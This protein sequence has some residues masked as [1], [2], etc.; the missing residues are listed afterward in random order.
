[1]KQF[2]K[3]KQD[4]SIPPELQPY[5]NEQ[6]PTGSKRRRELT[7]ALAGLAGLIVIGLLIWGGFALF[8]GGSTTKQPTTKAPKTHQPATSNGRPSEKNSGKNNQT[9]NNGKNN[10]SQSSAKTGQQPSQLPGDQSANSQASA[11][12]PS[13]KGSSLSNTGPGDTIALFVGVTTLGALTYR[14]YLRRKANI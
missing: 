3:H 8:G 7:T 13:G 14:L 11:T 1:M 2:W 4:P 10:Q 9:A 6:E 5:Y 12:A